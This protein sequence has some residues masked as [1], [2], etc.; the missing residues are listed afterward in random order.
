MPE[1]TDSRGEALFITA[2]LKRSWGELGGGGGEFSK[3]HGSNQRKTMLHVLQAPTKKKS[4]I[5]K[6]LLNTG[7]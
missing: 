7:I 3:Q 6:D 5:R 1:R 4:A 2:V